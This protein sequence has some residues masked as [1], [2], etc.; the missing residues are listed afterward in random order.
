[1]PDTA[2]ALLTAAIAAVNA[3]L[4]AWVGRLVLGRPV[5][6]EAQRANGAFATWWIALGLVELLVVGFTL[7]FQVFGARDLA[8]ALTLLVALFLL[9][10]A[11]IGGL[12]Y[13]LVYLYTGSHRL[14][15]PIVAFYAFLGFLTIY[16]IFTLEPTG[17]GPDGSLTFAK[18]QLSG[19]SSI[20]LGLAFSVPVLLA[21]LAYGTLFFRVENAESRYRI[22]MV[23]GAFIAQFGWSALSSALE[24]SKKYPDSVA[25]SLLGTGLGTL[26]A[27]VVILA[28]RPPRAI[29]DRLASAKPRA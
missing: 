23:A 9:I 26:S 15:W 17:F 27:I 22:G 24:L 12:V 21:A 29:R 1:M 6:S 14:F 20:A 3:V 4:Y 2:T 5:E 25:V 11:A 28:F 7:P 19:A 16:A 8:L 10:V 18:V 13:Y